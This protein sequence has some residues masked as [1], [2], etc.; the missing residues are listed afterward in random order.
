MCNNKLLSSRQSLPHSGLRM[1][2]AILGDEIL[3]NKLLSLSVASC[4]ATAE[5]RQSLTHSGLRM[6]T[7]ILGDEILRNKLLSLSVASCVTTPEAR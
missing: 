7:A 3:R 4:V 6:A 1:A 5:A 2:T